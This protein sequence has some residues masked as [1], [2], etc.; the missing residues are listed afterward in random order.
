[1]KLLKACAWFFLI[2]SLSIQ[3]AFVKDNIDFIFKDCAK[4]HFCLKPVFAVSVFH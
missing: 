4:Y 2:L 1:M 3:A